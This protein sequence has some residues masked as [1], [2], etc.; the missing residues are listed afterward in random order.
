MCIVSYINNKNSFY[1]TS[2]RDIPNSRKIALSPKKYTINGQELTFPKDPDGGGSW[3]AANST[4]LGCILN[5]KNKKIIDDN[6]SRGIFLIESL[7]Q[8]EPENYFIKCNLNNTYP[9]FMILLDLNKK[10]LKRLIWDGTEKKIENLNIK[11]NYLWMSTSIYEDKIINDKQYLFKKILTNEITK[12]KILDFHNCNQ[13]DSVNNNKMNTVNITQIS[14]TSKIN[15]INYYDLLNADSK[16][17]TTEI[18]N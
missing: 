1:L 15:D 7:T 2:N 10:K 17:E 11:Q 4:R 6:N 12:S 9:F 16:K 18:E 3:I 8:Q 5:V 13:Y 14:G